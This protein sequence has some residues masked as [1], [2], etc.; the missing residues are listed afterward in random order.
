[1]S[2][3]PVY[4]LVRD[5]FFATKLVKSA[6]AVGLAA[7][8]F[9]SAERLLQ[10]SREKEP[11]LILLDCEGLEREAFHLLE[12]LRRDEKL[13]SIPRLGYLSHTAQ[14]LKREMQTAGCDSV[15]T[16]S[17]LTKNLENLLARYSHVSSRV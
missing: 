17:E 3:K 4:L 15:Y 9:D 13:S 1:M 12:K 14:D 8:A 7:R 16:K 10:A 2:P 11:S 5:L 6:E